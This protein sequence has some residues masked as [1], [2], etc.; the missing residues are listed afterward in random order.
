MIKQ[1]SG[2]VAVFDDASGLSRRRFRPTNIAVFEWKAVS[3]S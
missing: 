3:S 2:V 1:D